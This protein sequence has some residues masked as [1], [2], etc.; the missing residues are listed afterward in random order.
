MYTLCHLYRILL[1]SFGN[2]LECS[3]GAGSSHYVEEHSLKR[4]IVRPGKDNNA[5]MNFVVSSMSSIADMTMFDANFCKIGGGG[6]SD[7]K[8][9]RSTRSR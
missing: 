9:N 2:N 3:V 6:R 5:R 8:N 7:A 1:R 4:V